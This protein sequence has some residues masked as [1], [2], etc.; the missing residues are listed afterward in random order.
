MANAFPSASL[1][2][3]VRFNE[4]VI[5]PNALQGLFKRRRMAVAVATKAN[6][7]GQAVGLLNGLRER[8]G[9]KPVWVRV[10]KDPALLLLSV[11]DVRYALEGSPHPFASDP[12]AKKQG[13]GHFQPHA[14]TISRG[15]LWADRRR[16]TE[17]VLETRRTN[18]ALGRRFASVVREEVA[19]A[20]DGTLDYAALHAAFQRL[21]R[22]IVLGDGAR[23]DEEITRLLAEL[24][25][26]ANG[27]PSKRSAE[28]EPFAAALRS[29]YERA[30]KGSLAGRAAAA[31]STP[32]TRPDGQL[33]HWLFAMQDTLSANTM[34]ALALLATH[35]GSDLRATLQE[36]MRLWPTT[37]LLSRETLVDLVW[38]H[39]PVP[40]GTNVL[41]VNAFLHRDPERLGEAADRFT[42]DGWAEGGA[43]A[44]DWGLNHFSHGP[45]G[46]PG[47]N[48]ALLIGTTAMETVRDHGT[49]RPGKPSLPAAGPLP[50]MLDVFSI[51]LE[52][53]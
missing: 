35:P 44:A 7:D 48:L 12:A 23:D 27:M 15:E 53:A 18:H 34:R 11:D 5:V 20:L 51:R 26:Q 45:Q 52:V 10:V 31:E 24:M 21:T 8:H 49:L 38:H 50:H 30:E 4:A 16:F 2:D 19:A 6:V 1:V 3:N 36:A 9:G 47:A 13:M 41:I 33:A 28:Y 17:Q 29:Y 43:F 25:G 14:L 40:A 32:D 37:P 42:P 22:R 39:V 46:C